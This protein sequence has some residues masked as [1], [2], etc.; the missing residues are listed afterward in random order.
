MCYNLGMTK[1]LTQAIKKLSRLPEN[2]QDE[3]A[4]MLIDV[5]AQ[6]FHPYQFTPKE[7]KEIEAALREAKRGKF[8]TD[9]E[10]AAVWRR[11]GL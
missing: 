11:F 2:R 8:A 9:E 1:L 4:K 3:L 10:V 7:L 6:D 5:A